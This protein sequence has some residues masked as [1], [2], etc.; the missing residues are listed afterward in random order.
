MNNYERIKQMTVEEMAENIKCNALNECKFC[1][2]SDTCLATAYQRRRCL[3]GIKQ[4]LL[5]E[6]KDE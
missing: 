5:K 4:W 6:V 1:R 3:D 2:H